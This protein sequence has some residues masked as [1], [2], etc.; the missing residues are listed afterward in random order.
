MPMLISGPALFRLL[1]G[2]G[3]NVNGSPESI[4]TG[5]NLFSLGELLTEFNDIP[6]AISVGPNMFAFIEFVRGGNGFRDIPEADSMQKANVIFES[7]S[8]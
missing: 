8:L 4:S 1:F 7:L 5:P 6:A 3:A 2:I